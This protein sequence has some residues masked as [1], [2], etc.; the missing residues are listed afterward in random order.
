MTFSVIYG[1]VITSSVRKTRGETVKISKK[2][3]VTFVFYALLALFILWNISALKDLFLEA[4]FKGGP[5]PG[6]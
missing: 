6:R 4:V 3:K 1:S 5:A 2:M